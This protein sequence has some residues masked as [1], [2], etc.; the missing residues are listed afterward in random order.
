MSTPKLT[1]NNEITPANTPEETIA[2][3]KRDPSSFAQTE[4]SSF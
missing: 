1:E 4:A 2:I 3:G